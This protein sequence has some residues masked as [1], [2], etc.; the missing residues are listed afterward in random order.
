MGANNKS[1]KPTMGSGRNAS[2]PPPQLGKTHA[3]GLRD[4][5]QKKAIQDVMIAGDEAESLGQRIYRLFMWFVLEWFSIMPIELQKFT[6]HILQPI[7]LYGLMKLCYVI[8][9]YI[10]VG[11]YIIVIVSVILAIIFVLHMSHESSEIA[12]LE[13]EETERAKLDF[14]PSDY[15][16]VAQVDR[17][18]SPS[19]PSGTH[20]KRSP[21]FDSDDGDV[22]GQTSLLEALKFDKTAKKSYINQIPAVPVPPKVM[23]LREVVQN[24]ENSAVFSS[25]RLRGKSTFERHLDQHE[26]REDAQ[27]RQLSELNQETPVIENK[28]ATVRFPAM[29][30]LTFPDP[31]ES[32]AVEVRNAE[33]MDSKFDHESEEVRFSRSSVEME[34]AILKRLGYGKLQVATGNTNDSTPKFNANQVNPTA[35]MGSL[36]KKTTGLSSILKAHDSERERQ[37]NSLTNSSNSPSSPTIK[38]KRTVVSHS[39]NK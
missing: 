13:E 1:I 2:L 17:S 12:A 23:N 21:S 16:G 22:H 8:L 26:V 6:V 24:Q 33:N 29:K 25:P 35:T 4:S 31:A 14:A 18:G 37:L 32:N 34:K 30:P 9:E 10:T 38:V 3:H 20:R 19:S 5:L 28:R 11:F 36:E 39:T 15:T 7:A 27:A